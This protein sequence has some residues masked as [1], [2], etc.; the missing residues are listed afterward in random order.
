M[1]KGN[2]S[3]PHSSPNE[4]PFLFPILTY[5]NV[6]GTHNLYCLAF[7]L[8]SGWVLCPD[9]G[10]PGLK[11][12]PL[13]SSIKPVYLIEVV[14]LFTLFFLLQTIFFL[15]ILPHRIPSPFHVAV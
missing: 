13:W 15:H 10:V 12:E 11:A 6:L 4:P 14:Y 5:K 8:L 1:F 7:W 3:F 2:K 9:H